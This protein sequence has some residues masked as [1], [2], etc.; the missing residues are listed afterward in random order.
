MLAAMKPVAALSALRERNLALLVASGTISSLGSGMAQVALAFAVL[1]IGSAS[2]LGFVFLAREIP[3][4]AFLLIGG[5][6]ADRVS[7][8]WLLVI[9]DATTGAAQA[10]TALLFL[11]HQ[12]QIWNVAALQVLFGVAN[13][14][15]RPASTGL[16]PQAVSASHLQEA[17][18]LSDLGRS[19][20]R[21]AGPAIGAAIVVAANPGWALAADA[22]SFIVSGLL[23][24]QMRIARTGRPQ[25]ARL[26]NDLRDGWGEFTS[27]TWV[28]VMVASFGFFQ[29]TLFPAMLI[30]GPVVAKEH[31]GGAGAWGAILAFQAAGSVAGGLLALR[32]R[33]E[34]PLLVSCILMVPT[35]GFL[36]LL[37]LAAPIAV[38]CLVGLIAGAGLTS[39]DILWMTTFQRRIPEHL[40]SRLSSF[41]WLGSVALNPLGYALVGPLAGVIGIAE[42]LYLAATINAVVSI[43][44]ALMPSIRG[45]RTSSEPTAAVAA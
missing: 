8:K 24:A 21:I 4:V 29:L 39:G 27:R 25:R 2:D 20:A 45:L 23:R 15:T 36:A 12:A 42:T 32:L 1:R 44:V 35:A 9:G 10:L 19:T 11:T 38:L 37:G 22:A 13:A 16:I 17:N 5:V 41:D 43:T 40:I 14:F 34:R 7:R 6:W 30:L 33:P 31:L 18:A 3:I 26:L 28:W